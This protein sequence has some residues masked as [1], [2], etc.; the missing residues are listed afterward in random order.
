MR[1]EVSV[2]AS[3]R[4]S[5]GLSPCVCAAARSTS[6]VDGGLG[7]DRVD[8]RSDDSRDGPRTCLDGLRLLASWVR[9]SP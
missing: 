7:D 4:T 8:A 2:V 5:P 1:P 6:N 3:R 9:S